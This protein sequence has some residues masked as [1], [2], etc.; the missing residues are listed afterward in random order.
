VGSETIL[1]D[2][3][4]EVRDLPSLSR[5]SVQHL[6]ISHRSHLNEIASSAEFSNS[7][8]Y[9]RRII[10]SNNQFEVLL[11]GW[12]SGAACLPHSHGEG[13][14]GVIFV[15]QGEAQNT[16]Y[17]E[18]DH[19]LSVKYS[20]SIKEGETF[21]VGKGEIHN[22]A[23]KGSTRV[24]GLHVYW[25]AVNHMKVFDPD[26]G[27]EFTVTGDSG[28]W[29]P[30]NQNNIIESR[31][32]CQPLRNCMVPDDKNPLDRKHYEL[33]EEALDHIETHSLWRH[34]FF[35]A[36]AS[37]NLTEEQLK[38]FAIQRHFSSSRFPGVLGNFIG[39]IEDPLTNQNVIRAC[40]KQL[41]EEAGEDC[42]EKNHALQ[43]RRLGYQLGLTDSDYQKADMLK[44]TRHFV[45]TYR[46]LSMSGM[47]KGQGAFALGSE[48]VIP[49]EMQLDIRGLNASKINGSPVEETAKHYFI[50][51]AYHDYRHTKELVKVM[52][53]TLQRP[54]HFRGVLEGMREIIDARKALYDG[55]ADK[56]GI[57]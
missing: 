32:V 41:W 35:E 38:I 56:C 8:P 3:V 57:T 22:T 39:S 20:E 19:E 44:G 48:P 36:F 17:R 6:L 18:T 4:K 34:P 43:L 25:P 53:P 37:G 40:A 46:S 27:R 12:E 47:Y 16:S 52:L 29:I 33:L 54:E 5:D 13:S 42:L 55:I 21:F 1:E 7:H 9:G 14:D 49:L 26:T 10:G 2:I 28:A 23:N 11:T 45:S 24:V 15:C 31:M 50:D 30:D 51:H